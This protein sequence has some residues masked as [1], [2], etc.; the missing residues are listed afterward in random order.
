ME[1]DANHKVH[2]YLQELAAVDDEDLSTTDDGHDD[3]GDSTASSDEYDCGDERQV[4]APA[5]RKNSSGTFCG[6]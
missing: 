2:K 1:V 3:D 6:F 5:P 4:V